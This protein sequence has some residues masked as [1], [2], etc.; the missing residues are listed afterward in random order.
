MNV[1]LIQSTDC[2]KDQAIQNAIVVAE[3]RS[4]AIK[5]FSK[6]LRSNPDCHQSYRSTWF[7]C[8]KININKPKMH[9]AVLSWDGGY[10]GNLP[11]NY[12]PVCGRNL[13]HG[14]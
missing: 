3:N 6:E 10:S 4:I 5:K 13:R 12:C 1:Y 2:L 14:K 8:K 7:S 9:L 11:I